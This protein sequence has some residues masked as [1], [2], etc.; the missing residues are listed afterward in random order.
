[1]KY[2]V[3]INRK[4]RNRQVYKI[5]KKSSGSPNLMTK[6]FMKIFVRNKKEEY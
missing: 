6:L 1:M 2:A 5:L 3:R 4:V